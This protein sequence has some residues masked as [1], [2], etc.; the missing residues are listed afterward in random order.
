MELLI[1][2]KGN[3]DKL[4]NTTDKV[5]TRLKKFQERIVFNQDKHKSNLKALD[6]SVN[7]SKKFNSKFITLLAVVIILLI[8]HIVI[9][10]V[11]PEDVVDLPSGANAS[12]SAKVNA[13]ASAT[14]SVTS[15]APVLA[16]TV[17]A[18]ST[19]AK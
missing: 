13:S 16:N 17:T 4:S 5:N 19:N 18:T 2:Q 14:A 12:V 15:N 9:L 11:I 8:V 3:I 10:I 7:S 1:S 6:E